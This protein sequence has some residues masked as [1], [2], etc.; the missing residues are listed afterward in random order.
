MKIFF[1]TSV[2]VAASFAATFI[3]FNRFP[4]CGK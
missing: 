1:D 4:L 3:T 2:L